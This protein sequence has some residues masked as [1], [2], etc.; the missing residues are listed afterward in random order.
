MRSNLRKS[1]ESK[2]DLSDEAFNHINSVLR[3]KFIKRKKDLLHEGEHCR[4]LA[5]V[6]K[7]CLRSFFIDEH[8][9]ESVIQ[10]ALEGS[11]ISD[12]G[13]FLAQKEADVSIEAIED[14]TVF[15][16]YY[17]DLE[18]L[19]DQLP[20]MDRF[21]RILY[22]KAYVNTLN[23]L[24]RSKTESAESRYLHLIQTQSNILNRVPL[25]HI[26]SYLGITPESLSRIRRKIAK[27]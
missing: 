11:W 25:N 1:F 18:R 19:Y 14:S 3:K 22:S 23:R 26:A 27:N 21:F 10:I 8:G 16:L 13:S 15:L 7:G 9:H 5:F 2:V 12:L 20:S 17:D 24:N 4:F 6:E